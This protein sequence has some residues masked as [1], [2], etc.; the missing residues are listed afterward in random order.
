MSDWDSN[1]AVVRRQINGISFGMYTDDDTRSRSVIEVTS[2]I[3]YDTLGT[4]LPHGLYDPLLG[5]SDSKVNDL[6]PT[7]GNNYHSCPGHFGHI[8]LCVPLYQIL[9]FPKLVQLLRIKCLNCHSFRLE[10]RICRV[11]AAKFHLIDSGRANEALG[12]DEEI[13]ACMRKAFH[14]L[15]DDPNVKGRNSKSKHSTTVRSVDKLLFSKISNLNKNDNGNNL[16]NETLGGQDKLYELSSHERAARRLLVKEFISACNSCNTCG[17]CSAHSPKI[18]QDASNKIFQ[19]P[20]SEKNIRINNAQRIVIKPASSRIIGSIGEEDNDSDVDEGHSGYNSDDTDPASTNHEN[21][22]LTEDDGI[23]GLDPGRAKKGESKVSTSALSETPAK[24]D[25]FMHALEVEA[26][27]RM[28]WRQESFLCS[29]VFGSAHDSTSSNISVTSTSMSSSATSTS[30]S[31]NVESEGQSEEERPTP[32]KPWGIFFTRSIPVTPSRFRPPMI[33]GTMTVE[34]AH[35]N[36][37]NKILDLNDQVRTLFATVQAIE[38]ESYSGEEKDEHTGMSNAERIRVQARAISTWIDLQSTYNCYIDSSKDPSGYTENTPTGIRQL[39]EKKEGIFRKHMMGKRVNFACRSVISPDPYI[40]TNEIGIPLHFASTLTYP[41]P[42]TQ[43]NVTEMRSLVLRGPR[44]H[45]GATWVEFPGGRRIDLSKM[46]QRKRE[47]LAARLLS[48]HNKTEAN[49]RVSSRGLT[50]VGRQMRDG[51]MLIMNRQPSLHKPSMMSHYVRV[52]HDPNQKTIRMHYANCNTYNADYDGDEMNGHFPQ[53]DIARAESEFLT[54]TDLQY[55]VPTDGTPLRGLIQDHVDAGVKLTSKDTFIEKWEYQQLLYASLSSLSG[56]EIIQSDV[57]VEMLPP[58][59]LKPRELWTGKQVITTLLHHLRKGKDGEATSRVILPGVSVERKAKTPNVAFGDSEEEHLVIVRDGELL[60]GILDK[61]AFGAT[62]FSLVH[63]VYEAYGPNKAGLLL[64]ALGRLFTAYL[65]YYSGHSCRMEDLILTKE[66]DQKRRSLVQATYNMGSRAAKAWADSDGGKIQIKPIKEQPNFDKPLK[67]FE[68]AGTAAKISE[69]LSGEEGKGNASNLDAYMQ[70]QLNPL[71]SEII[72]ICLPDGL[73]VPFPANTFGLMVTT[74][75]KGSTVNQSQVSC[76][77]GQQALEGRRV[78]RMSSGKT[79]PSFAPYDPNPRADGFIADRFLTGVRPQEYYFHCMAGREGLV[80]TAVKTSRSGYLQ[81][82]LV[83]HLEELKVCYDHTVRD[84]EGGVVQFLYGEDGIDPMKAAYLEGSSSTLTYIAR[85]HK[86]LEQRNEGLPNSSIDTAAKDNELSK[87]LRENPH[88]KLEKGMYVEARRLRQGTVWRRGAL[89]K[90]WFPAI[91]TKIHKTSETYDLKF[92]NDGIIV[93][94]MPMNVTFDYAGG[95]NTEANSKICTLIRPSVPDPILTDCKRNGIRTLIG[96]SGVCVSER[97]AGDTT[98]ALDHDNTLKSAMKSARISGNKFKQVIATRYASA[99]CEPGEAVG[100]IA[101]QSVGEPSTQMTLNTF[102]LAGAGANVTLG[103]P[104]LREII[105]TASQ[106]LKTP[107]MSVPLHMNVTNKEATRLTRFFTRLTVL[108]LI[109]SQNGI[110]VTESLQ[111]NE[112]GFWERAYQI[113]LK[114]HSAERIKEAFGLSLENIAAVI[115]IDLLPSISKLMKKELDRSRVDGSSVNVEGGD[116]MEFHVSGK[117]AASKK[118]NEDE[119]DATGNEDGVNASRY[120][121]KEEMKG[122]GEMDEEEKEI[123]AKNIVDDQIDNS[124]DDKTKGSTAV[125]TDDEMDEND[126]FESSSNNIKIDKKRNAIVLQPLRIDPSA[127]PLL[128][129]GLV[130]K[131]ASS[132][133][134]CSRPK[135]DNAYINDEEG[136]GRC[137]QTAGCNFSEFW[138]LHEVDHN[139]ILSNDT[140]AVRCAYGVEAARMNIVDQIRSVFGAYGITVD[141]RHLTLIADYMTFDGGYKA[142]NRIG[143]VDS[144]STF[145]QMSFETTTNFM[146]DAALSNKVDSLMSPSANIV[147]GKPIRHGTGAF[148][149]IV[150]Y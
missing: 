123:A 39:L 119:N 20:L 140:W 90:G 47:A 82:C 139:R 68:A 19:A 89:C 78:P 111:Q 53:N 85:N 6:C 17:N 109:A 143:M 114:F 8:E 99:L 93:R 65:Q 146:I 144:G 25:K 58:A 60:R 1:L 104:R 134:V 4:A 23:D 87:I 107:T 130:E 51:D 84:G 55:I 95:A 70:S 77:L 40:G 74:G 46:D 26:Q 94:S 44:Q 12:L 71:A 124:T 48:N 136:R 59:I 14:E 2:P 33:M 76:A 67:P 34:H 54:K 121:H 110:S 63:G 126:H 80:D 96:S 108:E 22:I 42:V 52:L 129:V 9:T 103:I 112:G 21:K 18:R 35:N 118:K 31:N 75:A 57:D 66:A 30:R 92:E 116:S 10:K 69:L 11:Y 113:T 27:V 149:C 81:R 36:Y 142:M 37:L 105:M 128:M 7:C 141:H 100:C 73:A 79:M 148:D 64:N 122:Y 3:A 56:L 24:P 106:S 15:D 150:K 145:L 13:A 125:I 45:P 16:N 132:T 135:I 62:D 61:S 86:A 29:K 5:P 91:I 72:K 97:V 147:M 133:L 49:D 127:S 28:T 120:S 98:K 43:R 38:S 117:R 137:L 50:I 101:A 32:S 41:T 88:K 138:N 83:K 131:A 115:S 102:H